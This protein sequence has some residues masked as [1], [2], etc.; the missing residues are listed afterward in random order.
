MEIVRT[1]AEL[2]D[3]ENWAASS[4]DEGTHYAGMTYEQ[5]IMDTMEWLRGDSDHGPHEN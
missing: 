4:L 5:G 2:A 3:L 1:E